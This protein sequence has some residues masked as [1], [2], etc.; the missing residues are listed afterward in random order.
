[1]CSSTPCSASEHRISSKDVWLHVAPMFH[2]V[3]AYAIFSI[4]F[5]EG[6]HL[7]LPSFDASSTLDALCHQGV[8]VTNMASTMV[9]LLL[10]DPRCARPLT[11]SLELLSCG[12][13]PLS[14]ETVRQSATYFRL[15]VLFELRHDR[16]LR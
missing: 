7:I 4:T 8:T 5:V 2:L 15:R 1:M 14:K 3:D 12:G 10:K 9:S 11:T 16:M 13:A 6:R